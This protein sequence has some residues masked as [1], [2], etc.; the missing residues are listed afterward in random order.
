[1][2]RYLSEL[3]S[4]QLMAVIYLFLAFVAALYLLAVAY[5][6]IDARRRG[7]PIWWLWGIIALIPFVGLLA[8]LVFRPTSYERDREE[9]ELD[10]MLRERELAH[11][12]SC[13]QCGTGIERDFVVCPMCNTQVRNV[14][15]SCHKPLEAAWKVCPWC[16]THIQ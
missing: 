15:P 6:C 9:Q 10:L 2:S 14:C 16:R 8:Y 13:P 5:V 1:M 4:P 11:F 7:A 12:G 3:M